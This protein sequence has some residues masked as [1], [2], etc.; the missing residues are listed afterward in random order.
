[1][2]ALEI[3]PGDHAIANFDTVEMEPGADAT[4]VARWGFERLPIKDAQYD[5]VFA[6]HVLEHI[7]WNRT[8][9]ALREARRILKPGGSLEVWVPDFAYIVECYR[10]RKCG[11]DWRRDNPMSDPMLWVN[12][13]L[14]T[15]GPAEGNW[16]HA[17]FDERYLGECLAACHFVRIERVEK[18]SRGVSHGPIDLGMRG[19]KP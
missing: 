18:R 3:G 15:Y 16:H 19:V 5:F 1:M 9:D 14:F 10:Q 12:G 2:K 6:S 13:R 4:F 7:P 8:L 17:C 11:D